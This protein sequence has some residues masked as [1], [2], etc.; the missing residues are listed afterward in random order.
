MKLTPIQV[1]VAFYVLIGVVVLLGFF[2]WLKGRD[3]NRDLKGV[4]EQS[5]RTD[6]AAG[7]I[8]KDAGVV[9][10]VID[11]DENAAASARNAY[12]RGYED[13]KRNDPVVAPWGAQPIPQRLRDLARQ[14]RLDR[15]RLGCTGDGCPV[16]DRA[17]GK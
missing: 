2:L 17:P 3:D 15:E 16:D 10:G 5:I 11:N 12:Q 6:K 7:A 13:A 4:A 9:Q 14:R 8:A 1:R